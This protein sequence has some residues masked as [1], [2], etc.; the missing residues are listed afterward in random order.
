MPLA[1]SAASSAA[2]P[3]SPA[4]SGPPPA[5]VSALCAS[6]VPP[7]VSLSQQRAS[8]QSHSK[9]TFSLRTLQAAPARHATARFPPPR[10]ADAPAPA[11]C[12]HALLHTPLHARPLAPRQSLRRQQQ[13]ASALPRQLPCAPAAF[14]T[15]A[16]GCPAAL[17][18]PP[19]AL[20]A[21]RT[22]TRHVRAPPAHQLSPFPAHYT[23]SPEPESARGAPRPPI[24]RAPLALVALAAA[25][26]GH[27][28]RAP[29]PT[30][31][32]PVCLNPLAVCACLAPPTPLGLPL[33][34]RGYQP[35]SAA[36]LAHPPALPCPA[37]MPPAHL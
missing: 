2:S 22:A 24:G 31:T 3:A 27:A 13:P 16:P 23:P 28:P 25:P 10:R 37:S 32:Q 20:S 34:L 19:S 21:S 9:R 15:L 8:I 36:L 11:P 7:P 35:A 29:A 4:V 12:R 1:P 6:V 30:P 26:S 18:R 33:L 17:C 5:V 14:P